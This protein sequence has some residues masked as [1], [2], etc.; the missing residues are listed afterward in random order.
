MKHLTLVT[1]LTLLLL[2]PALA[3]DNYQPTITIVEAD[4]KAQNI[5]FREW[6]TRSDNIAG[7][8]G[9][10]THI[11]FNQ[12]PYTFTQFFEG[13]QGLVFYWVHAL[14]FTL[15]HRPGETFMGMYV[16]KAPGQVSPP[17]NAFYS[18]GGI[19]NPYVFQAPNIPMVTPR[20]VTLQPQPISQEDWHYWMAYYFYTGEISPAEHQ[21]LYTINQQRIGANLPP[22]EICPILSIAARF[23]AQSMVDL[24]YFSYIHP[25]YGQAYY[26][27]DLFH[28]I[29]FA[30]LSIANED[31]P[32][33][34][35]GAEY[36]V[37][38]LGIV[39]DA[40][41]IMLGYHHDPYAQ[42]MLQL[43]A[44]YRPMVDILTFTIGVN[45]FTYNGQ[46]Q[47]LEAPPF[48]AQ[49]RTMVPLRVIVEALGANDLT[50]Y[51]GHISFYI[52]GNHFAMVVDEPLPNNM[53]TPTIVNGR[54][55]VPLAFIIN[56]L[57]ATARWDSNTRTAYIYV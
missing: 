20:A 41:A 53:G 17:R 26:I 4:T 32:L 54:T 27:A 44:R 12:H 16:I 50:F 47:P 33:N 14:Q 25:V 48:I 21:L 19:F 5:V 45:Q 31:T 40:T 13:Y 57:G 18:A 42:E 51:Q 29:N 11:V 3:A 34:A 9:A 30:R 22:L 1:L 2:T 24:D 8:P 56:Q 49:D 28:A 46:T 6:A 55:F 37:V 38:G 15:D 7:T 43:L 10:F 52:D 23:K 35:L 36:R 39:G